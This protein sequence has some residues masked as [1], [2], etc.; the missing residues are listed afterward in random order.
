M[1]KENLEGL[2][3]IAEQIRAMFDN[4]FKDLIYVVNALLESSKTENVQADQSTPRYEDAEKIAKEKEA[5]VNACA[6]APG[7]P[8]HSAEDVYALMR[9]VIGAGSVCWHGVPT[10]LFDEKRANR[11]A[12]DAVERLYQ[13]RAD[14]K[15][16][17]ELL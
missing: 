12:C 13:I 4:R 10:G 11:L 8:F 5:M 15:R 1:S 17:A 6:P 3:D 7:N 2:L 14:A 9:Q 16:K